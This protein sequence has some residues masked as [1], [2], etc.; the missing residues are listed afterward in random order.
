MEMQLFICSLKRI[1]VIIFMVLIVPPLS[2][3]SYIES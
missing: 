3:K 2:Q 1:M